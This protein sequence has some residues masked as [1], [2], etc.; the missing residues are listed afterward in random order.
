M[1]RTWWVRKRQ[2]SRISV[3]ITWPMMVSFAEIQK[4]AGRRGKGVGS[5]G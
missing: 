1:K 2:K 3:V 5:W 4:D